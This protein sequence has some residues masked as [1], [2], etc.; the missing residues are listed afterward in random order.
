LQPFLWYIKIYPTYHKG[1][2]VKRNRCIPLIV[3][4]ATV[5]A[6]IFFCMITWL[7]R[8]RT[9]EKPC[10]S[11]T[12]QSSLPEKTRSLPYTHLKTGYEHVIVQSPTDFGRG[13]GF[14]EK[15]DCFRQFFPCYFD[16][17]ALAGDIEFRA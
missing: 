9:S 16:G 7:P 5:E 11:S 15:F 4:S 2:A 6:G 17:I 12:L 1:A 14:K 10:F 13:G 8:C 3:F